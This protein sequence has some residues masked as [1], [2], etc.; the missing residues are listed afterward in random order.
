MLYLVLFKN[1]NILRDV[2]GRLFGMIAPKATF[3]LYFKI[4]L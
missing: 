2:R 3:S 1:Y 4:L